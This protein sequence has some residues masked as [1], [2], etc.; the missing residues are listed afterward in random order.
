MASLSKKCPLLDSKINCPFYYRPRTPYS[1]LDFWK[2]RIFLKI[3]VIILKNLIVEQNFYAMGIFEHQN[4]LL[5]GSLANTLFIWN[6]ACLS[7][8]GLS[9]HTPPLHKIPFLSRNTPPILLL[10][11]FKIHRFWP[12]PCNLWVISYFSLNADTL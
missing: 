9:R 3:L 12:F 1:P 6:M 8:F 5:A 2:I 7:K 11:D 4:P 10:W